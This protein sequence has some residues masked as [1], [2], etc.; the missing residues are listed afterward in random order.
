MEKKA[1]KKIIIN[2]ELFN[3]L[4]IKVLSLPY[5]LVKPIESII[6]EIEKTA[7]IASDIEYK[8]PDES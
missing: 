7:L 8:K 2:A 3:Q 6:S 5:N 4:I 1:E